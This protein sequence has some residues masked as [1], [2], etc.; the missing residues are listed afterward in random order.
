M[1]F[2]EDFHQVYW[3]PYYTSLGMMADFVSLQSEG[4]ASDLSH[5]SSNYMVLKE[6]IQLSKTVLDNLPLAP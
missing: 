6:Q 1:S 5:H 3:L 2:Q 4:T